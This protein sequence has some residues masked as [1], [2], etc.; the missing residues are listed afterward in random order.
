MSYHAAFHLKIISHAEKVPIVPVVDAHLHF[1]DFIQE[2]DGIR[3]LVAAM[4]AGRITK[5]VLFGL[6]VKKKWDAAEKHAP[7]YYLDDNSRCYYFQGTD[8]IVAEEF[9]RLP[10]KARRRFAPLVCG[11]NPTDRYAARDIERM[12][13]KYAFWRGIGEVLCRHDDLTN[14]TNEETA[15]VNHPAL[16]DVYELCASRSLPVLMHQNSTSVSIHD[17]Y[18]H[19]DELEEVLLRFPKTTFV[20]AH[21]GI[22]R[23]VY[24]KN[25]HEM[26]TTLLDRNPHLYVDISWVVYDD[27]ISSEL[28]PKK[29]WLETISRHPDR[30]CLGSDLCGHFEHLGKSLA[31]YN[32][33]LRRLTPRTRNLVA[34][35]NAERIWFDRRARRSGARPKP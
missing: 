12:L 29:H 23:R 20:W 13:N 26:V 1:V 18:E 5:A 11:F 2:S 31:R 8:E 30:F 14:M 27:V 10:A 32:G 15:R 28:E 34:S 16:C 7:H 9:L 6:P 25:Y 19:L 4:D 33:L 35:G 17:D 22:S 24:H 21:C 3:R